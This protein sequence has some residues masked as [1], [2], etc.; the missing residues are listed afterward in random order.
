MSRIV[1]ME[2]FRVSQKHPRVK[3]NAHLDFIR[4][5]PCI[6]CGNNI[7]TE[8]A[9]IRTESLLHGKPITGGGNKPDDK[10]TLPMCGQCHRTQ[11]SMNE[12]DF[13]KAKRIDPFG[14]ALALYCATGD[15]DIA[16]GIIRA[17]L[18]RL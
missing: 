12:K 13:W 14:T 16:D 2:G 6:C 10:W 8:A 1:P 17:H 11:H 4:S 9:H 5:L 3:N 18:Q 7:E 15:H